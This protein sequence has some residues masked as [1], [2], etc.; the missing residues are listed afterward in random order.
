MFRR[1]F[2]LLPLVFSMATFAAESSVQEQWNAFLTKPSASTYEPLSKMVQS[3]AAT[4][5]H[6][7]EVA[8]SANDFANLYKLLKLVEGGNHYAMEVAFQIR[9]LYENAAAPSEDIQNSIGLSVNLEP[10]FF[11]ELIQKYR[12]P[13]D[14]LK[15]LVVQTSR[16]AIDSIHA[17]REEWSGRIQSLSKVSDTRLLTLRDK[18][19]SLLQDEID[20]YSALPDDAPPDKSIVLGVLE[21][22]PGKYQ[23]QSNS[24]HVRVVFEKNGENWQSF[25]SNC[26]DQ[27]CLK[28]LPSDYPSE[29]TWTIAFDGKNLGELTAHTPKAYDAYMDVGLQDIASAGPIPTVGQRATE[30]GGFLFAPAYRPLVANSQPYFMDPDAWKPAHLPADV[31][32]SLR[33]QF[34]KQF[35]KVTNCANPEE[36]IARPWRYLDQDIE[37]HKTYSSNKKW[38]LAP[39]SL[40]GYRCDGPQ[41]GHLQDAFGGQWFVIDPEGHITF[42]GQNMWLVDAGD[43]DNDGKSEVVFAIDGYNKGGYELFYD[44]F[45]KHVEFEF[46]YH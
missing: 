10:A 19:I 6:D 33:Q 16:H 32:A 45:K 24:R 23:G 42:L 27:A 9:P 15:T 35:P 46:S 28:S 40:R 4:K 18:A 7:D 25:R 29:V 12:T 8:G 38:I 39:M 20:H 26:P 14:L 41:E 22:I 5:C 3:C 36:N 21:D 2:L 37:I 11:L 31:V 44:N 34:R 1:S 43:Y 17:H 30:Y 13:N